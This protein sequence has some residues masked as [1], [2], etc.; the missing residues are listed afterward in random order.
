MNSRHDLMARLALLAGALSVSAPCQQPQALLAP[1]TESQRIAVQRSAGLFAPAAGVLHGGGA[2]YDVRFDAAGMRFEPALGP[3]AETTQH[4]RMTPTSVGRDGEPAAQ[5]PSAALPQQHER[6]AVFAH[7]PG[8]RER[9]TVGVDGVEVSWV[10]D[11]RPAGHGDLVVCYAIDTGLPGPIAVAG[12]GLGF[13]LSGVGGVTIGGVTGVDAEGREVAGA[14]RYRAGVLEMSLPADF[15]DSAAYPLVL[16]PV[17]GTKFSIWGGATYSDAQPDCS[18]EKTENRYLVTFLRTFS[19]GDIRIRGQLVDDTGVLFQGVIWITTSGLSFRP[20]VASC[21]R[22]SRFGVSWAQNIGT[23]TVVLFRSVSSLGGPSSMSPTSTIGLSSQWTISDVDI[24][25]EEGE[26]QQDHAFVA[27]WDDTNDNRIYARRVGIDSSGGT[28]LHP[29]YTVFSDSTFNSYSQPA[30]S[31]ATDAAGKLMVVARRFAGLGPQRG[32]RCAL[33]STRDNTVSTSTTIEIDS[34]N[35]FWSPDV[36]GYGDE[37]V[38]AWRESALNSSYYKVSTR[39]AKFVSGSLQFGPKVSLGGSSLVRVDHPSVGYSPGKTWLGYRDNV[40]GATSLK[41]R[42]IDSSS[43]QSCQDLFTEPVPAG[44]TRIVVATTLSGNDTQKDEGLIVWGEG[45][46]IWA[47]RVANHGNTGQVTNL[48]GGCGAGGTQNVSAPAIGMSQI[49]CSVTGL[50]PTA[51]LTMFNLTLSPTTI[52]C[53]PC[54]WLQPSVA[55]ILPVTQFQS[56]SF[57]YM[58]PCAPG[59][60]GVDFHTQWTTIDPGTS[61]CPLFPGF[62]LSDRFQHTI[63]Q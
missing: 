42:G 3:A 37:W 4:L 54:E 32:I 47:Q 17:I 29:P 27:V 49:Y 33:V 28:V 34:V 30:I 63:G 53:G 36:D 25:S 20:R 26:H 18:Y 24:G 7:S 45:L 57:S 43:C 44:D 31:R 50:S 5:L 11:Q 40:F 6:A 52:S 55:Y 41:A 51:V 48:G 10:F 46:D 56:A 58:L 1:A 61:P 38:V 13:G 16:D 39:S 2:D 19:S 62:A 15:V 21:S 22:E 9:Y 8:V 60:V 35:E 14:L 23:Q 59:L 12:G